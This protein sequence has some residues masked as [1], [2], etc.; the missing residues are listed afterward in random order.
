MSTKKIRPS[1][2]SKTTKDGRE[3]ESRKPVTQRAVLD[4]PLPEL[5][6][7]GGEHEWMDD[8]CNKCHEPKPQIVALGSSEP[9]GGA[10]AQST[11]KPKGTKK[12]A[13]SLKVASVPEPKKLSAV[14]AA[15]PVNCPQGGEHAWADDECSKCHEPASTATTITEPEGARFQERSADKLASVKESATKTRRVAQGEAKTK[16]LSA[17]DAAAKV[18]REAAKPMTTREMIE[19]MAKEGYWTSPKGLTP[20][21]T[22]YSAILRQISSKGTAS[23]FVKTARGHFSLAKGA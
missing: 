23:R 14:N 7:Q 6:P 12:A 1:Q 11:G 19:A 5:C 13:K 4:A 22:L 15:V 21:A 3:T 17:L 16:N 2:P 20:A 8:E 18:L 10:A 9:D